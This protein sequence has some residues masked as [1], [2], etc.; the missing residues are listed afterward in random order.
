MSDE[1]IAK[2]K[3]D[4]VEGYRILQEI[5][6]GAAS[7]VY[8]VQDPKTKQIWALKHVQKRN[9]KEQRFLDQAEQEYKIS[10]AV[11]HPGVRKME[12][13]IKKGSLLN[14]KELYLVMELVDGLS[15]ERYEFESVGQ[16]LDVYRVVA[17]GMAA[18]HDA[19]FVHADMKPHNIIVGTDFDGNL[20]PKIIDLGQSCKIG[21]VKERIQ[22]TPDYI[23]PEQVH[24]RAITPKTDIYNL[25]AAMYFSLTGKNIPTAMGAK[26]DSLMGSLDDSLIEKPTPVQEVNPDVPDRLADIVMQS[27]EVNPDDRPDSMHTVADKLD[28]AFG[29]M[30]AKAE[31][32]AVDDED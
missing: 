2:Q 6:R 5:G 10:Q 26:Q 9:A 29:V 22:G 3:G 17:A 8:L 20:T 21:T 4:T 19:G 27:I 13:M 1:L 7:I 30:R 18:M 24:R 16:L 23:A 32:V 28:V 31:Q 14:T 11:N 15:L 25:G 12:R